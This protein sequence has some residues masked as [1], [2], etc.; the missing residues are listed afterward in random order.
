[1]TAPSFPAWNYFYAAWLSNCRANP[2]VTVLWRNRTPVLNSIFWINKYSNS[3]FPSSSSLS[4]KVVHF[5][6][7]TLA[8]SHLLHMVE[9]SLYSWSTVR[10]STCGQILKATFTL[11]R[12]IRLCER[13]FSRLNYVLCTE[14]VVYT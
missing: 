9:A 6:V 13:C 11:V 14:I 1:M 5:W 12:K 10:L 2:V 3:S 7:E 8:N 4:C